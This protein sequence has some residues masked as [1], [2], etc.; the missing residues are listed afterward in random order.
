MW[1]KTILQHL[2]WLK[3][4]LWFDKYRIMTTPTMESSNPRKLY[5][6]PNSVGARSCSIYRRIH[7]TSISNLKLSELRWITVVGKL[8]VLTVSL[9]RFHFQTARPY[10]S[11][12]FPFPNTRPYLCTISISNQQDRKIKNK[13]NHI[14]KQKQSQNHTNNDT[15]KL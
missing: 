4:T 7:I 1:V 8:Q 14:K 13:N 2:H 5:G 9:Y 12:P 3:I 11:V 15:S 6:I 10:L